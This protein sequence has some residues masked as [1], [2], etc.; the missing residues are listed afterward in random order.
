MDPIRATVP[1]TEAPAWAVWQRRLMEA[2]N[3]AV[4]PYTEAYCEADGHST[5]A[6][7]ASWQPFSTEREN[8][9]H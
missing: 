9:S 6:N 4:E 3:A 5:T 1:A 7:S 8:G 2:M